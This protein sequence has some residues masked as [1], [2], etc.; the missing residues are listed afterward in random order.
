MKEF[1]F[2][3]MIF[4]D[5]HS[6]AQKNDTIY[7]KENFQVSNEN[8]TM[9]RITI[10]YTDDRI[11]V[12]YQD[13][14]KRGKWKGLKGDLKTEFEKTSDSTYVQDLYILPDMTDQYAKIASKYYVITKVTNNIPNVKIYSIDSTLLSEGPYIN[15]IADIKD[16][17][18]KV[19]FPNGQIRLIQEYD[20]NILLSS[21]SFLIYGGEG[22]SDVH[23]LVSEPPLFNGKPFHMF[24]VKFWEYVENNVKIDINNTFRVEGL[25][26][27]SFVITS[28]GKFTDFQTIQE[29]PN[30]S[31]NAL[32]RKFLDDNKDNWKPATLSGKPVNYIFQWV[33]DYSQTF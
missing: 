19:Y 22:T 8:K 3:L 4:L 1:L 21:K 24:E 28:E 6:F 23:E 13:C 15:L 5:I 14:N 20:N 11:F 32:V 18:H 16:G 12:D 31:I 27:T 25:C 30:N 33:L 29:A 26:V 7:L 9:K 10:E 2:I 17:E